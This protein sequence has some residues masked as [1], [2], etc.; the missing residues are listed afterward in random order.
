MEKNREENFM[1]RYWDERSF[2]YS[3]LN[4]KQ[5]YSEQRKAWEKAIFSH[6]KED[7]KLKVLDVGTGPGFF[8][9]LAALRGHEVTAVDM[10]ENMLREAKKNASDAGVH[11]LFKKVGHIL[12]F[13]E[14]S[15]DLIVSRDVTWALTEPEK[16]LKTWANLLKTDGVLLYFDAE[17]N[18]HLKNEENYQFWMRYKKELQKQGIVF[19]EKADELDW[20]SVNL[21][22]TYRDRPAWDAQFWEEQGYFCRI[23]ENLNSEIFNEQE[24]I[25]YQTHPVFLVEVRAV[26][27]KI[28]NNRI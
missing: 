24:Q 19:Y 23:Y 1:D 22:M 17:W 21:P 8:A 20:V 6:V 16:Q 10:N 18:Y 28:Q 25:H 7:R 15:F 26:Y 3:E 14:E 13:E 11:V 12:P 5:F 27:E 2:S 9:I 4:R